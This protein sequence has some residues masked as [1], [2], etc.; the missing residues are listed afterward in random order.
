MSKLTGSVKRSEWE[1]RWG[2]SLPRDWEG[3]RIVVEGDEAF[4]H[5]PLRVARGLAIGL[6][7]S[8]LLWAGICALWS[9]T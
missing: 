2:H 9:L 4:Q 7:I 3:G 5:E 1:R 6:A 8:L